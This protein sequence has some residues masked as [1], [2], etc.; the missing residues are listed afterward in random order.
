VAPLVYGKYPS[1]DQLC[2]AFPVVDEWVVDMW[3]KLE[4]VKFDGSAY[5]VHKPMSMDQY[6]KGL[7]DEVAARKITAEVRARVDVLRLRA[8]LLHFGV[9]TIK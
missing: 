6:N 4:M 2:A 5:V 9:L 7:A 3:I 1:L 8:Q